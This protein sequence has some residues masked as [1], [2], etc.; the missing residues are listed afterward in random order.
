NIFAVMGLRALFFLIEN[1]LHRFHHL[2]KGLAVILFFI[3]AKM[4]SGI[5]GLHI[6][7][8]WSFAIVTSALAASIL[9]SMLFPKKI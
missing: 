5:F 8:L 7:S 2:Q 9:F 1:I 4:L 6:S 3:G